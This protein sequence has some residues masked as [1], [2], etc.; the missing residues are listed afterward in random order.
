MKKK[1]KKKKNN[2]NNINIIL[3]K[4]LIPTHMTLSHCA[5]QESAQ[6]ASDPPSNPSQEVATCEVKPLTYQKPP[7]K[8]R[9][10][11]IG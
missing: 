10:Q 3:A 11:Q 9:G 8:K 5:T 7:K 1:K 2:N 4:L 6:D